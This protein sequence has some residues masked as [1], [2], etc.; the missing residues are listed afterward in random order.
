MIFTNIE[1]FEDRMDAQG[2]LTAFFTIQ[3]HNC[4]IETAYSKV[5]RKFLFAFVDHN[6]GFTCSLEGSHA[7]G[8]INHQEAVELLMNCRNHDRYDPIHFYDFLNNSLPDV[9]FGEVSQYQ[10]ARVVGRAISEFENRIYF[11]HWRNANISG[12]QRNKTIELMG[13]EVVGFCDQN[14]VTPVFW[15]VPTERTLAA[16][17]NFRLDYDRYGVQQLPE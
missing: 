5:Q 17:A 7:N 11:N 15:S 9:R 14:R 4:A 3:Y 13:Y 6:V 10:Y 16:F 1:A 12:R 8:Y 2:V